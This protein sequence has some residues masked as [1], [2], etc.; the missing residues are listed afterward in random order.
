MPVG[1][2]EISNRFSKL[3]KKK[4]ESIDVLNLSEASS[5]VLLENESMLLPAPHQA[6][7]FMAYAALSPC[8][9]GPTEG[10][11]VMW[12]LA[13]TTVAASLTAQNALTRYTSSWC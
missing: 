11:Q 12:A 10:V 5:N 8:C 2:I 4:P 13:G 7:R 6:S 9:T 1:L 3:I